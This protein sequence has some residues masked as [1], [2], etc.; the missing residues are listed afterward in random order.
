MD[1]VRMDM[2]RKTVAENKKGKHTIF[3]EHTLGKRVGSKD[4][5]L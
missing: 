5:A 2:R 1:I 4:A 3:N